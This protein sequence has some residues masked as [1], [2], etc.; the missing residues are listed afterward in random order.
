[1]NKPLCGVGDMDRPAPLQVL[2][3]SDAQQR[4]AQAF[5]AH[6]VGD[7]AALLGELARHSGRSWL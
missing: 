1:M 5:A 4:E 7:V 2:H 3:A 6:L